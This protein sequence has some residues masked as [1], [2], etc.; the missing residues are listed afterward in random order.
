MPERPQPTHLPIQPD[1]LPVL[2][3]W[4]DWMTGGR[5]ASRHTITAYRGDVTT[6]LCFLSAYHGGLVDQAVLAKAGQTEFRAWQSELARRGLSL[7]SRARAAAAIRSFFR[8]GERTG[9]LSN[10]AAAFL[11]APRLPGRLPRPLS[12]TQADRLVAAAD[13]PGGWI[14]RRDQALFLLL[15]GA[16][17]RIDEA[18]SLS[19]AA[20]QAGPVLRVLGKGRKE[21]QIPL[22]P[23]VRA[24]I[25]AYLDHCPF[26]GSDDGPLFVGARGGRLN[27]AVAQRALRCL[28]P[29]LGLPDSATPHA[30][31][32]S[33]ATHLLDGG[34]DLR[35]IQELLGHASLSTTQRYTEVETERLAEVYHR[36]H[37]RAEK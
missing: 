14:G 30:L 34:A 2:T 24:A 19:R 36:A 3:A 11:R 28:R 6:F 37:P 35:A 8:W 7:A 33:F 9:R 15:Y 13:A 21:R 10:P 20:G 29:A 5:G 23:V 18:L 16:G 25:D 4:Y 17:L 32:H 12:I 1:L 31:R 27:A 22:L 26:A